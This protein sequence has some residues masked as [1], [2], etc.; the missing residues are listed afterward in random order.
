MPC[1]SKRTHRHKHNV[2]GS[3]FLF[4]G[5]GCIVDFVGAFMS[6]RSATPALLS[7]L[8]IAGCATKEPPPTTAQR[9]LEKKEMGAGGGTAAPRDPSGG[10]MSDSEWS[11]SKVNPRHG[12]Q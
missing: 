4:L 5:F 7:F 1:K 2:V 3:A 10:A 9:Q 8:L 12:G 11:W 6:L